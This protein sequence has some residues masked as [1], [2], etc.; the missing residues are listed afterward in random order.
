MVTL[1]EVLKIQE[2]N[3]QA[4][5]FFKRTAGFN[6][7][8]INDLPDPCFIK[9]AFLKTNN[10]DEAVF[11]ARHPWKHSLIYNERVLERELYFSESHYIKSL[12]E[13]EKET[14]TKEMIKIDNYA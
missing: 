3:P 5:F 8:R 4:I 2:E 7:S 1:D 14:K 9:I 13:K 6:T 12:K 10:K 11:A